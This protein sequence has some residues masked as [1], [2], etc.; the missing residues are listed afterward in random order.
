M[1]KYQD[2]RT[3]YKPSDI[4]NDVRREYRV[5]MSYHKAW[6]AKECALEDLMGSAEESYAKLVK[7]CHNMEITNPGSVFFI[8]TEADNYFKF[9]FTAPGRFDNEN[10]LLIRWF[11]AKLR[12]VIEEV[13]DLAFVI[14]QRQS[15]INGIAEVFPD[16]HHEYYMY[17]IQGNLKTRKQIIPSMRL[18]NKNGIEHWVRSYFPGRRYNLMM[19]NNAESL[20]A[21]FKRD[22]ELPILTLIENISTKLQQ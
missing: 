14:D 1:H 8:E 16:A 13:E 17:H 15:L 4:I 12:K 6:K 20:N 10:D 7:Y 21:L 2:P 11:F 5:V 9:F 22:R 18:S 19:L 3:I